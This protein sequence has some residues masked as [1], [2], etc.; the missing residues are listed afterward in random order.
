MDP[1]ERRELIGSLFHMLTARCE[2]GAA[3]A[4]EGQSD[5]LDNSARAKL[6]DQLNV[7]GRE[8]MVLAAAVSV[9]VEPVQPI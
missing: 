1:D 8:I 9:I 2:D 3:I 4:A 7:A 6:A 5:E